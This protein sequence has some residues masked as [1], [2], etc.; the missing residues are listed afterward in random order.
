MKPMSLQLNGFR[1]YP[2]TV[3]IDFTGKTLAAALGDTGAGKSSLLDAIF[4]ALFRKSSWDARD[5]RQFIADGATAM[6]V[7][8]TFLHDGHRWR[9]DRT[10]HATN[11]N[12]GRHHLTNLD[13]GEEVDGAV[14]VDAR[15]KAVLQMGWETFLRVVLLP[16][17]QFDR[18]LTAAGKERTS[19]LRE[20]FGADALATIREGALRQSGRLG[21]LLAQAQGQRN[22]MP[23]APA[24]AA[25]EADAAADAAEAAEARLSMAIN[26]MIELREVVSTASASLGSTNSAARALAKSVVPDAVSLLDSL[27]AIADDLAARHESFGR[28]VEAVGAMETELEENLR[29]AEAR[30]EGRDTLVRAAAVVEKLAAQAKVHRGE[31]TRL[32]LLGK[33][34]TA[35]AAA[36]AIAG[37]ELALRE[38]QV[39]PRAV[40]AEKA[41]TVNKQVQNHGSGVRTLVGLAA[42]AAQRVSQGTVAVLNAEGEREMALTTVDP[43]SE[44][45]DLADRNVHAAEKRLEVIQLRDLAASVAAE[46]HPGDHC[47]VCQRR[48]AADFKP[49]GGASAAELDEVKGA[50]KRTKARQSRAVSD[51]AFARAAVTAAENALTDRVA[52]LQETERDARRAVEKAERAIADFA[53]LAE[54]AGGVFDA[55]TASTT[56]VAAVAEL[57]VQPVDA[58]PTPESL[59]EPILAALT[60]C[61]AAV[62]SRA[63]GLRAGAAHEDATLAAERSALTSRSRTHNATVTEAEKASA[64]HASAVSTMTGEI[65]TLP[66]RIQE[67]LPNNVIDIQPDATDSAAEVI[68]NQLKQVNEVHDGLN[69]VYKEKSKILDDQRAL[70]R[71]EQTIVDKPLSALRSRLERWRDT[72]A[73]SVAHI[74]ASDRPE[75]PETPME[76]AF[77]DLR[78]FAARLSK[79]TATLHVE[80]SKTSANLSKQV[81]DAKD[82]L[83]EQA[84]M[85]RD[86]DGFDASADLIAPKHCTR[87][88]RHVRQLNGRRRASATYSAPLR[89]RSSPPPTW[90]SPSAPVRPAVPPWMS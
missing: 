2:R 62:A 85:F 4:F 90:T 76:A 82:R 22:A 40:A 37:R 84:A 57:A 56:L 27:G 86:V 48:L 13:T 10:M 88:S 3:T 81:A 74:T 67:L 58:A 35:E 73:E 89:H 59:T 47:P 87:L 36:I 71:E 42:A 78:T 11:A 70:D 17:G 19:R 32:D 46:A 34:L 65:H 5:L 72:V 8:F 31:R 21:Q 52:S 28:R 18:L 38:K 7:S 69:A 80:L 51:L 53:S 63:D 16:Q 77:V 20:L 30:G 12:G 75:A 55:E 64:R 39:K 29:S 66:A 14:A 79:T 25:H 24:Q 41:V 15:V 60:A 43:L 33:E 9:V 50:V 26:I 44:K 54:Q 49:G 6:S 68:A 1:S 83:G 23:D 45:L 61:E